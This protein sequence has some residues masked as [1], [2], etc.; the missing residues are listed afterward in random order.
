MIKKKTG[1]TKIVTQ[2]TLI[3]QRIKRNNE[4]PESLPFFSGDLSVLI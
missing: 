1:Q 3:Q 4:K 2:L